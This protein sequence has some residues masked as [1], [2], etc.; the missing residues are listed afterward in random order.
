M[1]TMPQDPDQKPLSP[2]LKIWIPDVPSISTLEFIPDVDRL[3]TG[4][5]DLSHNILSQESKANS[6]N[7]VIN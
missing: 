5:N 4:T 2:S 7:E 6:D 1:T 3:T